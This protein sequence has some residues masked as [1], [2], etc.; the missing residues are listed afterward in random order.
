VKT[1]AEID[2]AIKSISASGAKLDKLI[3][4]TGVSVLEHFA[5]H[6]DTGVVNRL[7]LAM[8]KGSR[9]TA[10]V[11]WLLAHGA[12]IANTDPGTKKEQPFRY[13]S[14]K[15]TDPIA[16][17]QDPWYS[18]KPD[19]APDEIF[20]LQKAIRHVLAKAAKAPGVS[21]GDSGTLKALALAV[22]IPESDVP[23]L[24]MKAV[25]GVKEPVQG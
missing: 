25:E 19:K 9:S 23:T 2:K 16:A 1:L 20:D 14:G 18:H 10:L 8:P 21:H 24:P 5:Q 4:D 6:K 3:Q 13:L 11:S 7:Y 22:G 12:L 17:A 15:T